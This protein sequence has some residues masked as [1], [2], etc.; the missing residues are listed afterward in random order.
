V[1]Y[2]GIFQTE[3]RISSYEI[4]FKIERADKSLPFFCN[5]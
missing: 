4:A 3:R 1:K 5:K 2:T